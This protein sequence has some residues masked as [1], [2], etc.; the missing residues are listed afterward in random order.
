MQ[1]KTNKKRYTKKLQK[2]GGKLT[3]EQIRNL[4]KKFTRKKSLEI[5]EQMRV[6]TDLA[7]GTENSHFVNQ[8]Y[9]SENGEFTGFLIKKDY[10]LI[11]RT[12]ITEGYVDVNGKINSNIFLYNNKK[13]VTPI[14]EIMSSNELRLDPTNSNVIYVKINKYDIKFVR[15]F[16]NDEVNFEMATI[17]KETGISLLGGNTRNFVKRGD[18]FVVKSDSD[19][20]EYYRTCTCFILNLPIN[21]P[22]GLL[23]GDGYDSYIVEK[24]ISEN[25]KTNTFVK[26]LINKNTRVE[27]NEKFIDLVKNLKTANVGGDFKLDNILFNNDG[28]FILSDFATLANK[29]CNFLPITYTEWSVVATSEGGSLEPF[30]NFI[31]RLTHYIKTN[32]EWKVVSLS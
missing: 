11:C 5:K 28:S 13:S 6:T 30:T 16:P 8:L 4:L 9:Q 15:I 21:P 12:P 27:T 26:C 1:K 32:G 7:S 18:R 25:E 20:N 22:A 24:Y 2:N 29:S 10:N 14:Q 17:I 19:Y 3:K 31:K 23:I